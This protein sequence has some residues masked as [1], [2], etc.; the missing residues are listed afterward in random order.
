MGIEVYNQQNAVSDDP[1]VLVLKLY[2]G[3][4]KY[5]SFVKSAMQDGNIESKFTYINKSIAIF[6][7][8]RKLLFLYFLS[9]FLIT[10]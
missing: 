8:L 10:E 2:E 6:D 3:V 9:R 7:E 5:L 4:I 1:Y